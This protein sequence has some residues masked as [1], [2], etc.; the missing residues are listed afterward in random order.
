MHDNACDA[1]RWYVVRTKPKQEVRAELNL[2]GW[3]LELLAP[4]VREARHRRSQ[5]GAEYSVAPLFPS[6]LFAR[7]DASE[8]LAKV[9]LTRGVHS[10]VGFGECATPVDDAIV[11]LIR[12]RIRDDGFVRIED[13]KPGELVRIVDGPLRAVT[14]IFQRR[15]GHDRAVILLSL[16]GAQAHVDVAMASI[17]RAASAVA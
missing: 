14:G 3:G 5:N 15:R 4:K 8:L 16:V 12:G 11:D 17:R 2:R 6:Y 1:A 9:R 7:F 10:V 13:P